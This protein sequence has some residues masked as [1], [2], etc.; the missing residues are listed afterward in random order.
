MWIFSH[1]SRVILSVTHSVKPPLRTMMCSEFVS[2]LKEQFGKLHLIQLYRDWLINA[3][4]WRQTLRHI[5]WFLQIIKKSTFGRHLLSETKS[6]QWTLL[7]VPRVPLPLTTQLCNSAHCWQAGR[8]LF[9]VPNVAF[10]ME[11]SH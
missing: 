7:Y 8:W 3:N 1:D 11:E 2:E 10:H 5:L 6:N 4:L 9:D